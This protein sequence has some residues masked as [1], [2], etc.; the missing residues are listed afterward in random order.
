MKTD[1][2]IW[3]AKNDLPHEDFM[4]D[5]NMRYEDL[6]EKIKKEIR[7][8]DKL[9]EKALDDAFIDEKEEKEV[10]LQSYKITQLLKAYLINTN[11][12]N[13][14]GSGL[15]GLIFGIVLGA[16]GGTIVSQQQRQ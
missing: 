4:D 2:E 15:A 11:P 6:P 10:I 3:E 16:L 8:F 12:N 1:A 9:F 5:H 13:N 14:G 7:E